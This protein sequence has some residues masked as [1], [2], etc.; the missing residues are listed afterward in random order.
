MIDIQVINFPAPKLFLV[1]LIKIANAAN[2][3]LRGDKMKKKYSGL[4]DLI[5]E[6]ST[7]SEYY[8]SLPDDVKQSITAR[9]ENINSYASLR[10]YAE[11]LMRNE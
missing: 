9:E 5:E 8:E 2:A 10:D 4:Y 7:A 3:M 6:D 1:I 11:N